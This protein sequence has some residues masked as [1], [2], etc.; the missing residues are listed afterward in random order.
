[1][2]AALVSRRVIPCADPSLGLRMVRCTGT[3][4]TQLFVGLCLLAL[5]SHG[6]DVGASRLSATMPVPLAGPV[7]AHLLR[8]WG[9]LAQARLLGDFVRRYRPWLAGR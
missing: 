7:L 9:P 1:V 3:A 6:I 4:Y 8:L 2:V 5:V